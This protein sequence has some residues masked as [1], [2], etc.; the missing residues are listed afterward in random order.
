VLSLSQHIPPGILESPYAKEL[1]KFLSVLESIADVEIEQIQEYVKSFNIITASL[2]KT[3]VFVDDF[4]GEYLLSTSK[5]VLETLFNNKKKFYSTRGTETTLIDILECYLQ[6]YSGTVDS[7]TYNIGYP[8]IHF[9]SLDSGIL[10]EGQDLADELGGAM[11][12]T[13]L[14]PTLLDGS[15][16]NYYKTIVIELSGASFSDSFLNLLKLVIYLFT[17]FLEEYT[18]IFLL[19]ANSYTVEDG[20]ED[21]E[22]LSY[23]AVGDGGLNEILINSNIVQNG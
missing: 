18:N 17:P 23:Q 13:K 15:W 20:G 22:L 19:I 16:S 7:L 10:P 21:S 8:L 3:R 4:D 5:K 11:T 6:Q 12:P 2:E 9:S 1:I 14:I